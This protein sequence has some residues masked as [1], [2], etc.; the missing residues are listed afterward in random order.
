MEDFNQYE[1]NMR[2]YRLAEL[3]KIMDENQK[4]TEPKEETGNSLRQDIFPVHKEKR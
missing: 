1:Y 2:K 3:N 4:E